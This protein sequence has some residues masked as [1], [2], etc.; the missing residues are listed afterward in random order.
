M[1][2]IASPYSD[3][4]IKVM[5]YRYDEVLKFMRFLMLQN[6][7]P[8]AVIAMCHP[9]QLQGTTQEFWKGYYMPILEASKRMAVLMLEG[10]RT[11]IGLLDEITIAHA[12][13]TPIEFY[14][15]VDGVYQVEHNPA[16]VI[17]TRE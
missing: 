8:I 9:L 1:I 4:D 13:G 12:L 15:I 2:Y 6:T 10:W 3:P 5:Q 16:G 17:C 14:T 7:S 11:S